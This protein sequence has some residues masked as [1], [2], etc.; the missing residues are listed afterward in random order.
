MIDLSSF[1]L[2]DLLPESLKSDK[3]VVCMAEALTEVFRVIIDKINLLDP[4]KEIDERFIDLIAWEEHVDFY[5]NTLPV[6][7]KKELIEKA[8]FLHKHKGTPA[9]VE[10]LITTIFGE[11]KVVEWF[12]YG[13]QPYRFKVV[14]SNPSVTLEKAEQFIR[15]LDSVKRKSARL[16]KVEVTQTED[17]SIY[18]A[19]VL[20][21]G[22]KL[23]I[24]QV[25]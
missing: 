23:E 14:T 13:G 5:D 6:E 19:G 17:M 7:K 21:V 24:K 4:T 15:A 10:E 12:E 25:M 2:I 11:G 22:D 1:R 3:E 8:E 20:H 9:A 18:Y 16:E